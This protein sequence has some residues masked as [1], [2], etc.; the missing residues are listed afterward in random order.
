MY[1]KRLELQGFKSFADKTVLDF[2]GG[3]TSV[4]GPN[5]SGKSN[6]SDAI[7]WVMGEMSAKSLR[8]ANMQ[9]VIFA[10]TESRKQVNF[11]EV[12]L[13]LDNSS[14]IFPIEFDEVVVT[15]RVMRSGESVYQIN[16]ANCRLKDIHELFMDTGLGRD[17]YSIIG[18]GNVSKILSTKAEDR[19]SFF[20]EAAGVSKYKHRKDEA[21]RKL[22]GVQEN[23]VRINDITLELE[24]QLGPLENQ[25]KKARKYIELYDEFKGLDVS[26]SLINLEKNDAE[27]DK[28]KELYYSINSE[29]EDLRGMETDIEKKRNSLYEK[30]KL[31][32]EEHAAKNSELM[33]NEAEIAAE[34]KDISVAE[35]DIKNNEALEERI[36]KEIAE[37]E[38]KIEETNA[39]I[40]AAQAEITQK[41]NESRELVEGFG[42]I[43]S[44]NEAIFGKLSDTRKEIDEINANVIEK[45][46]AVAAKKADMSGMEALRRSFIE[47]RE[48]VEAELKNSGENA[49]NTASEI[50]KD[51]AELAKTEEKLTAMQERIAAQENKKADL[52][53]RLNAERAELSESQLLFNSKHSKKRM[54]E[55]M[56]NEYD[57]FYRSVKLVLKAP[58]LKKNMI[59]GTVSGLIEVADEYVVAIEAALGS[60]LQ[61]IV[62]E[63]ENDAKAAIEF[64]RSVKGGRATFLPISSVSGKGPD[65]EKEIEKEKGF[66]GVA[67]K[68]VKFDKKYDGVMKSL[69]GRVI[70]FDN[71]DNAISF[72]KKNGYRYK[73]VTKDGDILNPGGS[74]S[75][76]SVNKSSG[77][78]SRANEIKKL[79]KEVA[80]LNKKINSLKQNIAAREEEL[81]G[82]E[83]QLASYSPLARDYE[84]DILILKNT[85]EHLEESLKNSGES[86][87]SLTAEL[88]EI[89][90]QLSTSGEDVA[91]LINDIRCDENAITAMTERSTELEERYAEITAEKDEKSK[92]LMDETLRLR[93]IE[94]DISSFKHSIDDFNA[95]IENTKKSIEEKYADIAGY[96]NRNIELEA[97]I[98]ANNVRIEELKARSEEI[99]AEIVRIDSEKEGIVEGLKGIQTENKDLTDKMLLLQQEL[100]KA[101]NKLTKLEMEAENLINKLWNSYELTRTTAKDVAIEIEDVRQ[102]AERTEELHRKIKHL[103]S[104]NV[105]AIEEY[106]AAKERYDFL[107]AQKTDLEKSQDNLNKVIASV[108]ELM[109]EHFQKNFEEINKSFS[110]VF[111]ELFGGGRGRLYLSDPDDIMESGI[112]IEVQLPGKGLQNINLYSGGEKS[113]I[114]IALLFAILEVKPTPFCI[115]D[116]IDAA[117]DDVNVSRFATY[118]KNYLAKTQFIV[119]TH[120]RGTMEAS[121]I[122]YGVTMQEKGVSKLLSLQID[123]VTED[124]MGQGTLS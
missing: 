33:L 108:Q 92:E 11:A 32:D 6:I 36:K 95:D 124:L 117:L 84:N 98:K 12:S 47:R 69:L 15:R 45:M 101:E 110:N 76:G 34:A 7:R 49:G 67:A 90:K 43:Q 71:I 44:E 123:D 114:A 75:G 10:G 37:A 111:K 61:N 73:V 56:E 122:M 35:N 107:S 18:Q 103:G 24:R 72:S 74:I 1:L 52:G 62:V 4:V 100:S 55:D 29:I 118:L 112:E 26:M 50:E 51:R 21:E 68:L 96:R 28:S 22:A 19:R 94:N 104:V 97:A 120:R 81:A 2:G 70:V 58:E 99:K 86:E 23:L 113:F 57:G 48:A 60:A 65:N 102:A 80:E 64:L 91:K 116:E 87:R 17:G 14:R 63:S 106:K 53:E 79:E 3:V 16:R 31:K 9:D 46:N 119:I 109:E 82:V 40:A 59:F 39:R 13:V 42:K 20:E 27:T 105:D 5:G 30:S 93:T 66:S 54:L 38:A 77:I 25:S 115:L 85:L 83:R 89:E 121:N 88:A 41:E 8:G 78:L